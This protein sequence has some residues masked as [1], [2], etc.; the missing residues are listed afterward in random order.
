VQPKIPYVPR[1]CPSCSS[2]KI[3]ETRGGGG[4][5]HN[6][7]TWVCGDCNYSRPVYSD[8]VKLESLSEEQL[9]EIEKNLSSSGWKLSGERQNALD[10]V[11]TFR[12]LR[13]SRRGV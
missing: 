12:Q 7:L 1:T 10:H 13:A 9:D 5:D 3:D 8:N 6:L 4:W 2:L 11:R